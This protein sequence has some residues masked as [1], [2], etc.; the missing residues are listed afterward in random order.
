MNKHEHLEDYC[1]LS[2]SER[3]Q[4]E[5]MIKKITVDEILKRKLVK[6]TTIVRPDIETTRWAIIQFVI[7][8][9]KKP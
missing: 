9:D 8:E 4:V 6:F 1:P 3:E 2:L 5:R 7:F